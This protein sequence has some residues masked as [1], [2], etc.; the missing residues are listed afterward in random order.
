MKRVGTMAVSTTLTAFG[1]EVPE[2]FPPV[3]VH[4]VLPGAK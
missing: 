3:L 4:P 2:A 1:E